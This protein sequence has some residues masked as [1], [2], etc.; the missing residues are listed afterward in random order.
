MC[1]SQKKTWQGKFDARTLPTK[2]I[3]YCRASAYKVLL[4][5]ENIIVKSK[6]VKVVEGIGPDKVSTADKDAIEFDLSEKNVIFDGIVLGAE[7]PCEKKE[8]V[9]NI[10]ETAYGRMESESQTEVNLGELTNYPSLWW[11]ERRTTETPR[12]RFNY[13]EMRTVTELGL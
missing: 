7:P 1:I 9:S 2:L 11:S 6:D 3:G 8:K 13:N 4:G 5:N 12:D 10:P